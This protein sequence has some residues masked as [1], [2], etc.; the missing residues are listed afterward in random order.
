[1]V[2]NSS[3]MFLHHNVLKYSIN[4]KKLRFLF[5]ESCHFY[6]GMQVS[7]VLGPGPSLKLSGFEY[8]APSHFLL[9]DP[10]LVHILHGFALQ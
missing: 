8:L 7:P 2:F 1:M 3:Q 6:L 10:V 9:L 5:C 4:F